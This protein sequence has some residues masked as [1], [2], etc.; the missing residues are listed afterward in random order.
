MKRAL[1]LQYNLN[2]WSRCWHNYTKQE[3]SNSTW[4]KSWSKTRP[5]PECRS[6]HRIG[7]ML[8]LNWSMAEQ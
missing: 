8:L 5:K 2:Q 1:S 3:S 7:N 6:C 4:C